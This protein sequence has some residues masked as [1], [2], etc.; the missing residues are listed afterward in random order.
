MAKLFVL[1][2]NPRDLKRPGCIVASVRKAARM[3]L[4]KVGMWAH[5][6]HGHDYLNSDIQKI[7]PEIDV[8]AD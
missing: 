2:S 4:V 3:N 1:S 6:G 5:E 8:R 7:H